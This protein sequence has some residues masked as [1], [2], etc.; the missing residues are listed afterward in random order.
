MCWD[1]LI[2][3]IEVAVGLDVTK[4]TTY[5]IMAAYHKVSRE[6]IFENEKMY[7]L[8]SEDIEWIFHVNVNL[9][10]NNNGDRRKGEDNSELEAE[11]FSE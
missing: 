8:G 6:Q 11:F 3:E 7:D 9:T 4:P 2:R 1:K 5:T 10:T